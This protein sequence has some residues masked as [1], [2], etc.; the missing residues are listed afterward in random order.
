MPVAA[1]TALQGLRDQGR[2]RPGQQVL[3]NGAAGGVGTFAVQIAKCLGA[4]ATGVCSSR[5]VDTVGSIGAARVIDYT[6]EDFT[7]GDRRYDIVFDCVGNHSLSACRRVLN[8]KGVYVGVG[9]PGS[10]WLLGLA[11]R[12]V[13]ILVVSR[14]VSRELVARQS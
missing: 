5:N 14:F 9:G 8:R 7:E 12:P 6:K 2:L 4:E 10:R 11:A 13:A 3:I 1:I